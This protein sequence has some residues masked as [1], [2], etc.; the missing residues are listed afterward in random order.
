MTHTNQIEALGELT[1][2]IAHD[3]N[4]LL[5]VI[6]SHA[7]SMRE[8]PGAS[9]EMRQELETVL[10]ACTKATTLT[11]RLLSIARD[12]E[13]S[14]RRVSINELV[15]DVLKMVRRVLPESIELRFDAAG[16][17]P[18]I[19]ADP[20]Q[21]E[22]SILNLCTNA[23]EAMPHG[24][25]LTLETAMVEAMDPHRHRHA[26]LADEPWVRLTVRD[27]GTGMRKDVLQRA[28][29][30][31]FST[32]SSAHGGGQGLGLAIVQRVIRRHGG[33]IRLESRPGAGTAAHIF[34]PPAAD[35]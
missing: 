5:F 25:R 20:L 14:T 18:P 33:V 26:E 9:P 35:A 2:S 23:R 10:V 4:N 34:L 6:A 17:L 8:I 29:E 12:I 31:F 16:D 19:V 13:G 22:Q 27:T 21:I 32:R 30:P 15:D 3:I 28:L 1:S 7:E 11:R 24:G